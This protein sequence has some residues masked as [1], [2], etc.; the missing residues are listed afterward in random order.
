MGTV[1]RFDQYQNVDLYAHGAEGMAQGRD[2][3]PG[4]GVQVRAGEDEH[5]RIVFDVI[6]RF[7]YSAPPTGSVTLALF[8]VTQVITRGAITDF[9]IGCPQYD[10]FG[11]NEYFLAVNGQ[12]PMNQQYQIIGGPGPAGSFF[13][14][15][16][17]GSIQ[18]P[19]R[20]WIPVKTNDAIALIIPAQTN[21]LAGTVVYN[22]FV[23]VGGTLYR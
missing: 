15:C 10:F 23:R 8:T 11:T 14:F 6:G 18:H 20:V 19:R 12:A 17:V 2:I 13:G 3:L 5:N 9:G 4:E 21:P 7:S 1:S 16:P 22:L